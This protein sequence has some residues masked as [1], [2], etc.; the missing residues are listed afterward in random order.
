M[1]GRLM[2]C[3]TCG[4]PATSYYIAGGLELTGCDAHPVLPHP[5]AAIPWGSTYGSSGT[6]RPIGWSGMITPVGW[7]G[8]AQHTYV[9]GGC[10]G[11]HAPGPCPPDR[12]TQVPLAAD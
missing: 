12:L 9:R 8:A 11:H 4:A 10:A 2:L 3:G 5:A 7:Q 1:S 6:F